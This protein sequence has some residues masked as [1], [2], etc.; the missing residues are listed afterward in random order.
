MSSTV[1]LTGRSHGL[2]RRVYGGT[3]VLDPLLL[4]CE[5]RAPWP[6]PSSLTVRLAG[7]MASTVFLRLSSAGSVKREAAMGAIADVKCV[8]R[9][10]SRFLDLGYL[11]CHDAKYR[12]IG[13]S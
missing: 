1:V 12:K 10:R 9:L 6:R 3:H 4:Q 5:W 11:G 8:D 13:L 2:V 7:S